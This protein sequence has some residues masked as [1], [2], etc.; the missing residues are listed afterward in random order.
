MFIFWP[1]F[2][3]PCTQANKPRVLL[4]KIITIKGKGDK[5]N[6]SKQW[7]GTED[8]LSNIPHYLNDAHV[9]L[10][11]L[12]TVFWCSS[13][14]GSAFR[15]FVDSLYFWR[16]T[17]NNHLTSATKHWKGKGFMWGKKY[18][19]I[20]ATYFSTFIIAISFCIPIYL[21]VLFQRDLTIAYFIVT[22]L[23]Y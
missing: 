13:H 23:S 17:G 3:S 6:Q 20:K 9:A 14:H 16:F 1:C 15:C 11:S 12:I 10:I 22:C 7:T 19:K 5:Q 2:S 8:W 21:K 4:C 18:M